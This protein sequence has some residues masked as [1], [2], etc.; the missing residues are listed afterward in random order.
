MGEAIYA[1]GNEVRT[2]R[3]TWRQSERGKI[4]EETKAVLFPIDGFAD[5][6]K[7]EVYEAM[8]EFQTLLRRFFG[9][10]IEIAVGFVDAEHPKFTFFE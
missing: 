5:V 7:A 4:T 10:G 8:E 6:N 2:R 9:D 3:W 1:S